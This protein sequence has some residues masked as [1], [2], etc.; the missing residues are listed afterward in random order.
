MQLRKSMHVVV[1]AH[2]SRNID[3]IQSEEQ[4]KVLQGKKVF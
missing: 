2:A 1:V 3:Q 4:Y